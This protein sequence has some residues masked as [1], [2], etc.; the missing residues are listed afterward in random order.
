[1]HEETSGAISVG[2]SA[3]GERMAAL[4]FLWFTSACNDSN[5][6]RRS[7]GCVETV[8]AETDIPSDAG[9][10]GSPRASID[11]LSG[12]WTNGTG[13]VFNIAV[14]DAITIHDIS[15]TPVRVEDTS[16][17]C[18]SESYTSV[19]AHVTLRTTDHRLDE[20]MDVDL[21]V[22]SDGS[23]FTLQLRPS[24]LRGT[25]AT[26]PPFRLN[27]VSI[28]GSF[29]VVLSSPVTRE[30]LVS[31]EMNG[32]PMI[33]DYDKRATVTQ[34]MNISIEPFGIRGGSP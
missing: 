10:A 8:T 21:H 14:G 30:W 29:T 32:V 34:S 19:S 15:G 28:D 11:A 17:S 18:A 5:T 31:A 20:S 2:R 9:A 13:D 33:D 6:M 27:S 1:M 24:E 25:I 4:L 23:T 3:I 7:D 26:A 12:T 22:G 16:F